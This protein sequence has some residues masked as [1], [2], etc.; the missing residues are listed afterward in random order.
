MLGASAALEAGQR[1][2][3]YD[4]LGQL[5]AGGMGEVY[6]ARDVG[7]GRKAALKVLRRSIAGAVDLLAEAQAMAR[8]SHRNV[9]TVYQAGTVRE[10]VY[11]AMEYVEGRTLRA[12]LFAAPRSWRDVVRVRVDAGRGLAAAP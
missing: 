10:Q 9:V 1:F 4:I 5:G 7:L 2:G 11:I 3:E 6:V 8:L 12:W